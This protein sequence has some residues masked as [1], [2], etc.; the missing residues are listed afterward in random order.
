MAENHANRLFVGN[1]NIEL[2]EKELRSI[3]QPFGTVSHVR[4]ATDPN[5]GHFRGFAFVEMTD[6]AAAARAIEGLNGRM[7]DGRCLKVRLGF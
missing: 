2:T 1:F 5:T 6:G 3:L 4:M 7:L